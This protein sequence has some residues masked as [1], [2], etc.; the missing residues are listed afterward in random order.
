MHTQ[1][2]IKV[3][4]TNTRKSTKSYG[5]ETNKAFHARLEM[6]VVLTRAFKSHTNTIPNRYP[7]ANDIRITKIYA[8]KNLNHIVRPAVH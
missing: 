6:L 4:R 8:T 1:I 7:Q 2:K 3:L 5:I